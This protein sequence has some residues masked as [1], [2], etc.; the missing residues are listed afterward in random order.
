MKKEQIQF[1]LSYYAVRSLAYL[2][3]FLPYF[4]LHSIG[5]FLGFWSFYFLP[6]LRKRTLSNLA[7]AKDLKLSEKELL[8]TAKKTFQ[9]LAITILEYPKLAVEKNLS[10]RILCQN[11][12]TALKL[13]NSKKG[14]I[15][16]CGHQANWE[17]LFL[18]GNLRMKGVAI[19][20]PFHNKKLYAWIQSIREKTGGQMIPPN[21]ALKQGLKSLKAGRFLG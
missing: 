14:L 19:G 6:K 1:N 7:L 8:K 11:P 4:F 12:E 21:L 16:F 20:K 18:D 2:L 5:R 10:R 9:S 3:A 13:Y 17:V 15:F